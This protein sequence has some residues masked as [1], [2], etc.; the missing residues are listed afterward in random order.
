MYNYPKQ[1]KDECT[2]IL[3]KTIILGVYLVIKN[4]MLLPNDS[5]KKKKK[6]V[7]FPVFQFIRFPNLFG[8]GRE[9]LKL[10]RFIDI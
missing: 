10:R 5:Q 1:F 8:S 6:E 7:V 3:T 2:T 4:T 9:S